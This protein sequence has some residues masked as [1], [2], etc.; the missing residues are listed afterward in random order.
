MPTIAAWGK[1]QIDGALGAAGT[2]AAAIGM[3]KLA[4]VGVLY[5]GL[6]ILGGGAILGGVILGAI[7]VFVIERQF[8]KAAGFA[9]A[10]VVA[11]F[12]GF[13]HGEAIGFA[14]S[15]GVAVSYLIV[16]AGLFICARYAVAAPLP[17]EV[18]HVHGM[19]ATPAE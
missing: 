19:S 13:I 7:A 17:A 18:Q 2:S 12:F 6:E 9:L 15:P 14:R 11:T 8:L 16:A 10:G 1:I 5:R 4:Q 3:D